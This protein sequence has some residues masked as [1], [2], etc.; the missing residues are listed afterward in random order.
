MLKQAVQ[1]G[2][3]TARVVCLLPGVLQLAE[4]LGLAQH[5]RVQ[6]AGHP[7]QVAGHAVSLVGI[8]V[9]VELAG[10]NR[11]GPMHPIE[12]QLFAGL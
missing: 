2:S 6:P 9:L 8:K 11:V 10:G 5:Q 3:E 7:D 4:N 12:H 1:N